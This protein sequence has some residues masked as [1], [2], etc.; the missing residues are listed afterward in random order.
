MS[1]EAPSWDKEGYLRSYRFDNE[2]ENMVK[3]DTHFYSR[4]FSRLRVSRSRGIAPHKP[5]LLLSVIELFGQGKITRNRIPLSPEL[6]ASFLKY[7]SLL[8]SE[9]Y[10]SDVALPFFHMK[11]EGFWH[12]EPNPGFE[13]ILSSRIRLQTIAAIHN[14]IQ[15]AFLD[16]ALFGLLQLPSARIDLANIL[17]MKWFPQ[18][19]TDVENLLAIDTFQNIQDRLQREGGAVYGP[20]DVEDE[21]ERVVRNTAFRRIVTSVYEYRCAFCGLQIIDRLGQGVVDGAHIMPFS[22][23]RD[24]RI[25]NGISLCKNHHWAFD[26]GWFGIDDDYMILVSRSLQEKAPNANSM[27][28]FHRKQILLPTRTTYAPRPESLRWHREHVFEPA[29]SV[30]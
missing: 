13:T 2:D 7:W 12:L 21:A 27:Q 19:T 24:D 1:Q 4:A 10:R 18:R 17:V 28:T 22:N 8:G 14:A 29:Q 11:S 3:K 9:S 6:I 25:S 15:Y 20:E 30:I 26:R 16:D 23:F 5:I